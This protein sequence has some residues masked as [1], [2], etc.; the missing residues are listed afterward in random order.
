MS[1][2]RTCDGVLPMCGFRARPRKLTATANRTAVTFASGR[3]TCSAWH[4]PGSNGACVV[5]ATGAA[6]TKEP[7]ADRFAARFHAAGF[8]VLSFDYR[9][10]GD[11]GGTPRQVLRRREQV[12]DL[13]AAIAFA[14]HLSDVDEDRI[15]AWGFS[16]GGGYVL[17]VAGKLKLAAAIAQNTL[18][19]RPRRRAERTQARDHRSEASLPLDRFGRHARGADRPTTTADS[20]DRPARICRDADHTRCPGRAI[21]ARSRRPLRRLAPSNCRTL[22]HADG[23]LPPRTKRGPDHVSSSRRRRRRRPIGAGRAG[24]SCRRESTTFHASPHPRRALRAVP[25]TA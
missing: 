20:A 25:R 17:E 3:D 15:A 8:T 11:S 12:E 10:F 19:R 22:S 18:R 9:R 16:L 5:M 14:A 4:Y 24:R 1:H 6:I 21:R 2:S 13:K 23:L 7:G